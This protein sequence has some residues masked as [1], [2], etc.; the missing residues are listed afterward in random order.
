MRRAC[1]LLCLC[2]AATAAMAQDAVKVDPKH[3]KVEVENDQ[4]RVLRFHIGPGETSQI[5]RAHV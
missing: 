1:F 4:V 3:Y 5:G 2:L